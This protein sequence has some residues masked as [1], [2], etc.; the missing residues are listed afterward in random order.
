MV[1]PR[2]DSS[3]IPGYKFHGKTENGEEVFRSWVRQS[4]VS[5]IAL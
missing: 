5:S 4:D 1:I 2:Y 3:A